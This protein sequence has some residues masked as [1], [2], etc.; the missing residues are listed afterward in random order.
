MR[1]AMSA[2]VLAIT[3]G[4]TSARADDAEQARFH[5]A[6]AREQYAAGHYEQ[7]IRE[8]FHEQRLAPNPRVQFN[9]ALCFDQLHRDDDAYLF[10]REY[11]A[12]DDGDAA[13]RQ[14]AEAAVARLE[15]RVARVSVVSDPP[16]ATLYVDD[17]DHGS[18]GE[19][20]RVL[21]L[22]PGHHALLVTRDG[23][24]STRVEVEAARGQEV[25][26]TASLT[27]ITGALELRSPVGGTLV[28]RDAGGATVFEGSVAAGSVPLV[29]ILAPG[30]YALALSADGYTEWRGLVRVTA[31]ETT[32]TDAA[33]VVLPAPTGDLTITAS[34]AGAL[35]EL[36][37]DA[38]GFAPSVITGV[39]TG[40]HRVRVSHPGL[41]PWS[42]EIVVGEDAR[43][44]LTVSLVPPSET[45]RS[46]LTWVTGGI[47]VASLVVGAVLGG[48]ALADR[49]RF[50]TLE[51]QQASFAMG[52]GPAP[53]GSLADLR[54]QQMLLSAASDALLAVGTAAVIGA[55]IL[56]FAT[57]STEARRSEGTFSEGER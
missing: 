46:P 30:D 10:F 39:T 1:L 16:G 25:R 20:P 12:A 50:V 48:L 24:L 49:D 18:Y 40:A 42:G 29:A 21:V 56:Y 15:P 57:E 52:L 19:A 13:R 43:A 9:I 31:S 14:Q 23:Y 32:R 41:E 55:V 17:P 26:A 6:L 51:M 36:D 28:V 33:P 54:D 27:R 5:D 53:S 38:A 11:L 8:F 47:G 44:W 45:T 37:G 7:A 2:I 22:P 3:L 35:I 4:A 34:A